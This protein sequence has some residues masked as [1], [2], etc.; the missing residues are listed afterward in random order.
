MEG[1]GKM[2]YEKIEGNGE[3]NVEFSLVHFTLL[4]APTRHVRHEKHTSN[5][6]SQLL[7]LDWNSTSK[8]AARERYK[9]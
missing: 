1:R 9:F 7:F 2:G 4:I 8:V 5:P 3:F 6:V